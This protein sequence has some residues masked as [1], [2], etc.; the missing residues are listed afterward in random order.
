MNLW[1]PKSDGYF[2]KKF[3]EKLK[4]NNILDDDIE[5]I[6]SDAK[7]ILSRSLNPKEN[8]NKERLKSANIVLGYI[9]SGKTTSMEA[10]SCMARDNGYKLIILLSGHVSNLS[11]QTRNRVY[12]SL[13]MYGWDRIPVESGKQIDLN[14]TLNKL[15]SVIKAHTN[16]L[17]NDMEKPSLL[18]VAMKQWQRIEKIISIFENA[19]T[20]NVDLS[21]IPTLL[22]DDEADHYSLDT[23]GKKKKNIKDRNASKW[24]TVSGNESLEDIS[25]K[26]HV[27]EDTLKYLN[28]LQNQKE[29]SLSPGMELMVERTESTTHRK[30]KRLRQ[31]LN[32][33]TFLGY[34]ATPI[35]N[36]LISTVNNLSPKSGAVLKPGRMY[37]GA[38]YFFGNKSNQAKHVKLIKEENINEENIK[39]KSLEEALR[40]FILGVSMGIQRNDHI[41]KKKRSM[42]VHPSTRR[43]LHQGWKTW[44][45]GILTR[46]EK[47]Y[48]SKALN[49]IDSKNRIDMSFND[50]EKEFLE[51]YQE[52]KKTE[53]N[54]PEYNE[55][56]IKS[57][58]KASEVIKN[59]IILFNA[60]KGGIPDIDWENDP[61]YARILVGGIGLERGY[62]IKGLTVSYIVRE[63]GTDDVVYQRARFFG[64]HM[65]YIGLVRMYLPETLIIN[66]EKQFEQ[67]IIVR[68]KMEEVLKKNGNLRKDLKR[69]FPFASI[70]YGPVRK[71]ILEHNLKKFPKG[72][73]VA[74]NQAHHLDIDELNQNRAIYKEIFNLK[75]KVNCSTITEHVY[76]KSLK[77]I[78]VI[79]NLNLNEFVEKYIKHINCFEHF[80]DDYDILSDLV[81]WRRSLK[82]EGV[83]DKED[84]ELAIMFMTKDDDYGYYRSVDE[85]EFEEEN[86]KI[87]IQS[88][89]NINRPGHDYIHYEFLSKPDTKWQPTKNGDSPFGTPGR[90]GKNERYPKKIA[91]LQVYKFD[92]WS[93]QKK[94]PIRFNNL[95]LVDVPYF[96]LYIP[97]ALGAG[98][99]GSE[100]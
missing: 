100:N 43:E 1:E 57:I 60:D 27:S 66:F 17:M 77:N 91:T 42:L 78:D 13:D 87:R 28:G 9:Q 83:E 72:G 70:K 79:E 10:V 6:I 67:E 39:P 41:E 7:N 33:H 2:S 24:H 44:V 40:I 68:E 88:G 47:A 8:Q 55:E 76:S 74:D 51:S 36:F 14:G 97:T 5:I 4:K 96:R 29:I 93:K 38:K 52:L 84:L 18:I 59:N 80:A 58:A 90:E 85:T 73:I 26:H 20:H 31:L 23:F 53:K 12:S 3:K 30:I 56:F 50:V 49:L 46:Y 21:K 16:P 34:T 99:V 54:L 81:A 11:Q 62:T 61:T 22:I 94:Q 45:Q 15:K 25:L 98:Y 19:K 82:E 75:G 92:I 48:Q 65:D 71:S 95:D 37:T 89:A 63:S 64:Y 32:Q 35:A 69:S 86:S